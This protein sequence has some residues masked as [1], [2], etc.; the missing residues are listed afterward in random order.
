MATLATSATREKPFF[1][2]MIVGISAIIVLGFLQFAARGYS[3]YST[4]P[5]WV[6]AHGVVMLAWLG[7]LIVQSSLVQRGQVML[8]RQ[9]GILGV[10]LAAALIVL[11]MF[12]AQR[13]IALH[14]VPPFFTDA[15]FL[16]LTH[17]GLLFFAGM[18]VAAVANRNRPE[19]HRRLMIGAL[20]L[21]M[22]P[23][24]GRLLPMPLMG[25]WGEWVI[26]AIQLATLALVMRHDRKRFI[27]VHPATTIS[28]LVVVAAHVAVTLA[29]MTPFFIDSAAGIAAN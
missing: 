27:A 6:H 23:A 5:L 3:N 16:S 17:V 18:I 21:L 28:A 22:E 1:L 13:A 19:W 8:H 29:A 4:A 26:M 10:I 20:V 15:F 14:R 24:F 12:T 7:L 11:G 25:P 2:R 9:L